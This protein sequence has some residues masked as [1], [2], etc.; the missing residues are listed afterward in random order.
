MAGHNG[1]TSAYI[2]IS[3]YALLEYQY[4][5]ELIPISG[6]AGSAGALRLENK[7]MGTYQ[8]LNTS[9]SV[10]L[11]GNVLDRS[12]GR[13][14]PTLNKWAYFD[15]D[16][17]VPIYLTNSNFVVEDQ[18]ANLSTL[19]GRYD[20]ARLHILSGFNFPGLDGIIL[21]LQWKEWTLNSATQNR[22]FDACN[23]VYLKGQEQIE[24]STNPL[25]L[26]DRLYDRYIDVKVPSLYTVQQDFWNSPTATNTI[27]Y[28][29]TFNNV[30][31]QQNSQITA[32]LFEIDYTETLN[33]NLYLYTGNSYNAVFNSADNY[34]QL[35]LVIKEDEFNDY[36]EYYPTW[37][38]AFLEVYINDLN[39]VG[40]DWVVINQIELYEQIG[41][42]QVRSA[43]MT[44]LQ[45]GNFDQPMIYRPV[46]MNSSLAFS[47][48]IDYTMRFFNRVDNTEIVRK[49]AYTSTNVKKYGKQLEKINVLQG[50]TPVKVYNKIVQMSSSDNAS[51]AGLTI[52]KEIIT[53]NIVTPVFYDIN[54]I[55]ISSAADL[56]ATLGEA[57]Y[58]QGTN[59]IYIGPFDNMIKFKIFTM[60]ADKSQNVSFDLSSFIG[61]VALT[62]NTTDG[63]QVS[64]P[65]YIDINLA[66]PNMGEVVFKIDSSSAVKILASSDKD[67]FIVN[68]TNPETVIYSGKFDSLK[69][70]AEGKSNDIKSLLDSLNSQIK[71]KQQALAQA[72][73][74]MTAAS[75]QMNGGT[76]TSEKPTSSAAN[77]VLNLQQTA[78][79][80]ITQMEQSTMTTAQAATQTAIQQ[81]ANGGPLPN[82]VEIP[83]FISNVLSVFGDNPQVSLKPNVEKPSEPEKG[84]NS[85]NN[86]TTK[87]NTNTS[88][89]PNSGSSNNSK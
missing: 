36:I 52:P 20:N 46:I 65:A 66:N 55:S 9:P 57:V 10:K 16:T 30:G 35:G 89:T 75:N 38:G 6:A 53:Q 72:M 44:M 86:P 73:S 70:K 29:Y 64:I 59:T 22:L 3:R 81:A 34:S 43:N 78:Q 8:F 33:G 13:M 82:I 21:Q 27:G 62:F 71:D 5:N 4:E 31:F 47:Y 56:S 11:T 32:H 25:F 15:I 58:P 1:H 26:G 61:N 17:A 24:F 2:Q 39:S 76:V 87:G 7:Y 23:Y 50:F 68:Q 54:M 60:S 18:T 49:A 63:I 67:Y 40:G 12:A 28:N 45:D 42:G 37:N 84:F 85:S 80:E 79:Q 41:T 74:N 48:T 77:A 51:I 19:A 14:G 69:N 88:S 83:G